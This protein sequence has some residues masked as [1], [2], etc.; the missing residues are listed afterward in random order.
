MNI[1]FQNETA[2]LD[3][4][5]VF[6]KGRYVSASRAGRRTLQFGYVGWQTFVERLDAYP[7]VHHNA[8]YQGGY[9][10]TAVGRKTPGTKIAEWFESNKV[11]ASSRGLV[12]SGYAMYF[13]WNCAGKK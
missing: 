8:Y 6:V 2:T 1:Q 3:E 13:I 10:Q 12:Y 7:G 9:E 5:K 4:I 11:H